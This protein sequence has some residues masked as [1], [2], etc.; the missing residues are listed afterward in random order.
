MW[1]FNDKPDMSPSWSQ[2]S[3]IAT[4]PVDFKVFSDKSK[5]HFWFLAWRKPHTWPKR[6]SF[7]KNLPF[8]LIFWNFL[9]LQKVHPHQLLSIQFP[10]KSFIALRLPLTQTQHIK[11]DLFQL[12]S[13]S[14]CL[15]I[16]FNPL[17]I[18][19]PRKVLHT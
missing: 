14:H 10:S 17:L 9:T 19:M 5:L 11:T 18:Q 2:K 3:T 6:R 7:T 12:I 15:N 13:Y 16:S 8:E 1:Y 4:F